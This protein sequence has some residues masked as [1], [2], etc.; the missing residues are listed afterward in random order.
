[1][2]GKQFSYPG[3]NGQ[4]TNVVYNVGA[5]AFIDRADLFKTLAGKVPVLDATK[6]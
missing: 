2:G 3:F 1:L 4:F 6:P 5:G